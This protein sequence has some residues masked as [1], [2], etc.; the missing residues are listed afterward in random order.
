M[1]AANISFDIPI[2]KKRLWLYAKVVFSC[3]IIWLCRKKP[4]KG[5]SGID[6]GVG[7]VA[8]DELAAWCH[9]LAHEHRENAVGIGCVAYAH[10]LEYAVG[11]VHGGF[12]QLLG[13]HFTKTFVS[14]QLDLTF[15]ATGISV[16]ELAHLLVVPAVFGVVAF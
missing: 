2:Q 15:V 3:N 13:V 9:V 1:N 8:F 6:V 7:G 16:D 4:P 5:R 10:L 12:A 14:L 11:R